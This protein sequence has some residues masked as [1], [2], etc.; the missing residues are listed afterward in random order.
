MSIDTNGRLHGTGT[1]RFEL[2]A[3]SEP[4]SALTARDRPEPDD[5]GEHRSNGIAVRPSHLALE[6]AGA[7]RALLVRELRNLSED[8]T[9]VTARVKAV[10]GELDQLDA[11]TAWDLAPEPDDDD[12]P[13]F[14]DTQATAYRGPTHVDD[15][16][17][18]P[19]HGRF[20]RRRATVYANAPYA[21]R[22]QV[23]RE[24]TGDEAR[25][26]AQLVGYDYSKTGGERMGDPTQDAPNSIVLAADTTK[27]RAYQRLESFEE[28][29]AST[30]RDGSPARKTSRTGPV[31]SR[32]V[33]GLGD[34]GAVH[35]YYDSISPF[36]APMG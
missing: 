15:V 1:G 35:I 30:V 28:N 5:E 21:I 9:R 32:L 26:L 2:Q 6:V 22:V 19:G 16:V 20:E 23:E 27:G 36:G 4:A 17:H 31:G 25:H 24:L 12:G 14:P 29:L 11:A 10:S 8:L 7:R 13:D 34:V 33:E 3:R 18:V